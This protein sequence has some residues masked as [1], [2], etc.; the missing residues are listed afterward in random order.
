MY[1]ED[2]E[3]FCAISARLSP[4][5]SIHTSLV[6]FHW[7]VAD[8]SSFVLHLWFVWKLACLLWGLT[9]GRNKFFFFLELPIRSYLFWETEFKSCSFSNLCCSCDTSGH[10]HRVC[11]N[12][13]TLTQRIHNSR[14]SVW[15]RCNCNYGTRGNAIKQR[16]HGVYN[17]V[18]KDNA[19][20]VLYTAK[21]RTP[22][23]W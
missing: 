14:R 15:L 12:F 19:R 17:L 9:F 8:F 20:A 3:R 16:T 5:S 2:Y 6:F 18:P 1:N 7:P 4:T 22:A 21:Q 13:T 10:Q 11:F 23:I